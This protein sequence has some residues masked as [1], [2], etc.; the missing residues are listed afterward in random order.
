LGKSTAY[1]YDLVVLSVGL[2][3]PEGMDDLRQILGLS[4]SADGFFMEAHPKLRPVDTMTNGIFLAGVAQ[5]PKDIPDT[6]AQASGAAARAAI[7][8]IQGEV[9][10]E[11]I[12]AEVSKDN[13]GGC[14]ICVELCPFKALSIVDGKCEVNIALCKG[15]GTCVGA[16]PTGALDQAHFRDE[17]ILAQIEAAFN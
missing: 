9:E 3:P 2:V 6:V 13:C 16:C 17:Q 7:P 15:C 10:I 4:K 5:G 14:E 11:P 1:T 8:M 12:T